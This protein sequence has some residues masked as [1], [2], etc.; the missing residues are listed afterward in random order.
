V[1]EIPAIRRLARRLAGL[2]R[3]LTECDEFLWRGGGTASLASY[4][5]TR[6]D[7]S[8]QPLDQHSHSLSGH[9]PQM[10]P[11]SQIHPEVDHIP[12]ISAGQAPVGVFCKA[13]PYVYWG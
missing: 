8:Q 7:P 5:A 3:A 2:K 9:I 12:G 10:F 13:A 4:Y 6:G 11:A 1:R